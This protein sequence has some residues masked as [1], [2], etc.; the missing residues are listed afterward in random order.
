MLDVKHWMDAVCLKMNESKME[1]IYLGSK[2]ML[3]KCNINTININGEGIS[4]SDKVKYLGRFSGQ[5]PIL[6]PTCTSKMPS[7]KHHSAK[8]KA[9]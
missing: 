1:F 5:H 4:R 9:H 8:N 3:K 7:S 6:L 2:Q